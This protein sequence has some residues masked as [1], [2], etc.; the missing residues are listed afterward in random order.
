VARLR[1]AIGGE[2]G[3][4]CTTRIGGFRDDRKKEARL[5]KGGRDDAGHGR[6]FGHFW[7]EQ[8]T[9]KERERIKLPRERK[10]EK[11]NFGDLQMGIKVNRGWRTHRPSAQEKGKN[12]KCK[13]R[14]PAF[15]RKGTVIREKRVRKARNEARGSQMVPSVR[16]VQASSL[17]A[18]E[19]GS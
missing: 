14:H 17:I 1:G 18:A 16:P 4:W 11:K 5:R 13:K 8:E 12:G 3:G 10:Q 6:G 2:K 15:E 19:K 9:F 7:R